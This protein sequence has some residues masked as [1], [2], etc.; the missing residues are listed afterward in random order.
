[1]LEILLAEGR[2]LNISQQLE[3]EDS[4]IVEVVQ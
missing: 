2:V 3:K 1:M 4:I